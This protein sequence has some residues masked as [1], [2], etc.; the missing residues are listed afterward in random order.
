MTREVIARNH[1]TESP[2]RI[3]SD[4]VARK[5]GMRG[6]L[7]PGVTIYGYLLPEEIL[8]P[9]LLRLLKPV[10]DG[11]RLTICTQ[12]ETTTAERGGEVCAVLT[13]SSPDLA[14]GPTDLRTL[15]RTLEPEDTTPNIPSALLNLAN[16]AFMDNFQPG[17]WLHVNSHIY[18]RSKIEWHAPVSVRSRVHATY[19]KKNRDF[20]DLDVQV[21]SGGQTVELIRHTALTL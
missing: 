14:F 18:P 16:R 9:H 12:N 10:Y 4:D 2:N 7:V 13:M 20:V 19:S 21:D 11:D 8:H 17:P 15:E 6:G 5:Y 1:A 3:H